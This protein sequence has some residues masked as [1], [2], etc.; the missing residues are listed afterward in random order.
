ML[1]GIVNNDLFMEETRPNE[2]AAFNEINYLIATLD[3]AARNKHGNL[4]HDD[5]YKVIQADVFHRLCGEPL[6]KWFNNGK[7]KLDD[8]L[9]NRNKSVYNNPHYDYED[10]NWENDSCACEDASDLY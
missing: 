4:I 9:N 10:F 3:L 1:I 5:L 2:K 7:K 6:P 8:F